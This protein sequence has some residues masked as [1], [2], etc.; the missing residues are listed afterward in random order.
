MCIYNNH[1]LDHH[2]PPHQ[3][4]QKALDHKAP[5][6]DRTSLQPLATCGSLLRGSNSKTLVQNTYY[7]ATATE[8]ARNTTIP[9]MTCGPVNHDPCTWPGAAGG[10]GTW[11]RCS[12]P[13]PCAMCPNM[14]LVGVIQLSLGP[15]YRFHSEHFIRFRFMLWSN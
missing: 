1:K 10:F 4:Q 13:I 5:Q 9:S 14:P 7:G 3:I 15:C 2:L 11:E 12:F 6:D 8:L